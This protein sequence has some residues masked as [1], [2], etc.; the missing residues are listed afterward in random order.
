MAGGHILTNSISYDNKAKGIDANSCPDIKV[1]GSTSYNNGSYNVAMYTNGKDIKTAYAANGIL[2]F[3]DGGSGGLGEM[4]RP[5]SQSETALY[6]ENNYYWNEEA[7]SSQ[8]ASGSAVSAEW[9]ESLDTSVSPS[10]NP[11]GGID[12]HGLL[13]LKDEARFSVLAGARGKAWGQEEA[14]I[15]AV[16]DSTV[17]RFSDK[18]YIPRVGYGE[19]L[20]RY[21][22]AKVYNLARSGAS[23]K[24]FTTMAEYKTLME[25]T[26]DTPAMGSVGGDQFLIIGF[27]H[28]DEKTEEAR[29]TSPIGDY[30][31][32]GSF[33]N[34]LYVNYVKPALDAGVIPVLATPI[35]RLT[36]ENTLESYQSASGH[37][38]EDTVI[39]DI[40]YAGGDYA[41]AIR[42]LASDLQAEGFPVILI[43]LTDATIKE[44][45]AMG[46]DA[47]WLH[48]FTGAKHG[49][50]GEEI[51]TG[52]EQT[53]TNS[54]GAKMHAWLISELSASGDTALGAYSLGKEKPSY[55][56]DFAP[57]INPD[58]EIM[59][60]KTPTEEQMNSVSWP[61][62]TDAGG[63]LW[64]GTVFGDIGGEEKITDANFTA[65]V[66]DD[67]SGMLLGVANN[68]GK[69]ASGSDG[70]LFYYVKL[71]AGTHFT[72]SAKAT[73]QDFFANNQV[74]F[75]L[76]ARDDLYLDSYLAVTLGD[77][78]SAGVRNQGNIINFGRKSSELI[79]TTAAA[80]ADLSAGHEVDLKLSGTSDG[81]TLTFGDSTV[82]AGYDYPLT[83]VD[84]DYIYVGFYATRNCSV[85]YQDIKLDIE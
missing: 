56:K 24:D 51:A 4:I 38:T 6:G 59:D 62:F 18:Y 9:F 85:I 40:T 67:N 8:N 2:S 77:Y 46:E 35:A 52:L 11:D 13:L 68:C 50:N 63:T 70:F 61:Q 72:L 74:S 64:R 17:S 43:D 36:N 54:F 78:V 48:A 71:P 3:R 19:E 81:F 76:M 21:F 49:E 80:T 79:G 83:G 73:I 14:T 39:G 69:I 26:L 66:L 45:V 7:A 32:E 44:N 57:S 12:M 41:Q 53:H 5:Q 33:A 25:G 82:S 75:G 1:Y 34:S 42:T 28:N 23:S 20:G 31:T 10:R 60:Y 15:W 29:F 55:D 22:N 30:K 37:I 58:F 47:K 65:K 27:G 16:G 84:S